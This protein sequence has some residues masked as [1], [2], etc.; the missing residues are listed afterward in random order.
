MFITLSITHSTTVKDY[1]KQRHVAFVFAF[2]NDRRD[3]Q[4]RSKYKVKAF[5][6]FFFHAL[7]ARKCVFYHAQTY[8]G[9]SDNLLQKV[10]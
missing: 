7:G 8:K 3:I 5:F 6:T 1:V 9:I 4:Q 10:Y 2:V